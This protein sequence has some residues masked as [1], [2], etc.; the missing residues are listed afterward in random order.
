[1]MLKPEMVEASW[2][3]RT[4]LGV[5]WHAVLVTLSLLYGLIIRLRRQCYAL[6]LLKATRLPVPVLMRLPTTSTGTVTRTCTGG[7]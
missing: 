7:R 5:V 2:Y 4:R 3:G 1:M 6:G